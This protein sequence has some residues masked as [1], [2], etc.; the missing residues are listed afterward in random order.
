MRKTGLMNGVLSYYLGKLEHKNLIVASRGPRTS[1]FY[2]SDVSES[3]FVSIK[4]LR[5]PTPR[6]LLLALLRANELS[7]VQLVRSAR[8]SPST[9]SLYLTQLVRDGVVE[10]RVIGLK[11]FYRL[12]DRGRIGRLLEDHGPGILDKYASNF[13]DMIN[14]LHF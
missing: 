7:F 8:R 9:V 5:R 10:T 3:D 12:T 14:P 13:E 11:K 1:R 6:S 2:S 4:A